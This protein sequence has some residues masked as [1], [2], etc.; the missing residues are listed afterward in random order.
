MK[1]L[2]DFAT[3]FLAKP[4]DSGLELVS[5]RTLNTK[6]WNPN[7]E[8]SF[9]SLSRENVALSQELNCLKF[10]TKLPNWLVITVIL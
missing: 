6:L 8:D 2:N 9:F 7:I 4:A 3:H 5:K 1:I 10:E